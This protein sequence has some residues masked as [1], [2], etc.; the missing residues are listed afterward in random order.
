[1]IRTALSWEDQPVKEWM[2]VPKDKVF[3]LSCDSLVDQPLI[4]KIHGTKYSRV[5]IYYGN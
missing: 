5:P 1:M 4:D 2:D 3:M